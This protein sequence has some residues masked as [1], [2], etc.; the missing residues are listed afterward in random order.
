MTASEAANLP[1]KQEVACSIPAPPTPES[2]GNRL[3][4][5][6]VDIASNVLAGLV[7]STRHLRPQA[8]PAWRLSTARAGAA[9]SWVGAWCGP[10]SASE[11]QRAV[12]TVR[13][14]P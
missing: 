12:T 1:Y 7:T 10:Y 8:S 5:F 11:A 9:T 6:R 2:P 3:L 4:L 14:T 13:S